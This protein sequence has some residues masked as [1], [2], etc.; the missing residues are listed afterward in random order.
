MPWATWFNPDV[1]RTH[2]VD[3]TNIMCAGILR[4]HPTRH[5]T[6]EGENHE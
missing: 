4:S 5:L 2:I 1:H 6:Q 3:I